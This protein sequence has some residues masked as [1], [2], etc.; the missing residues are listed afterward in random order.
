MIERLIVRLRHV[1]EREAGSARTAV[2]EKI[3][4]IKCRPFA[5]K[6]S[7]R[8]CYDRVCEQRDVLVASGVPRDVFDPWL[9]S[10]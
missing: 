6:P 7:P 5:G 3:L 9:P 4:E 10:V 8:E 2:K 1:V